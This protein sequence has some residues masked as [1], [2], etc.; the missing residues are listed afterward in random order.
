[1][2]SGKTM[3]DCALFAGFC[4]IVYE[5]GTE[6]GK[7]IEQIVPTEQGMLEMMQQQQ[8]QQQMMMPPMWW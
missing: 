2:P 4:Y 6:I 1:M 5:H 7:A 3:L 8:A